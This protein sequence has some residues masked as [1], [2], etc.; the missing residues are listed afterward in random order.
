M[1]L[2]NQHNND[3]DEW[4]KYTNS[5]WDGRKIDVIK[6][7]ISIFTNPDEVVLDPF[8]GTGSTLL[9]ANILDRKAIGF[10]VNEKTSLLLLKGLEIIKKVII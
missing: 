1:V 9:A 10:E 2:E 8:M 6:R 3:S 4:I 7:I 5:L